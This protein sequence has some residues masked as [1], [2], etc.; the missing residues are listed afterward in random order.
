LLVGAGLFGKSLRNLERVDPGYRADELIVG[1]M[2]VAGVG[3]SRGETDALFRRVADR[4]GALPGVTAV[5]IAWS[6]PT[7]AGLRWPSFSVP[8]VDPAAVERQSQLLG[9]NAA[10]EDFLATTGIPLQA[11]RWFTAADDSSAPPVVVINEHMAHVYFPGGDAVGH[12]VQLPRFL[13]NRVLPGGCS[14]IVGVVGNTRA[15]V[16]GPPQLQ[17]YA[18]LSQRPDGDARF[19]L[20]RS[21]RNSGALVASVRRALQES[22]P[23]VP[24]ADVRIASTLIDPQVRPWRLGALVFATLSAA[25]LVLVMGG[26]YGAV[27]YAA[28]RRRHEFGIR[29][30]LGASTRDLLSLVLGEWL[31]VV[32]VGGFVG[33][34]LALAFARALRSLL[35]GVTASDS[36]ILV[37]AVLT[38]FVVTIAATLPAALRST[39]VDPR[40][41]LDTQ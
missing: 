12:C 33:L 30:A 6:P 8:G 19:L 7:S 23:D 15:D 9:I 24:F 27:S 34:A 28:A 29:L 41:S 3:Y 37:G 17:L 35:V 32:V 11:G 5:A 40:L 31:R 22:S 39:R 21:A 25:A 13:A 10:T 38:V 26:L 20:V 36:A 14:E 18:P 4:V 1:T 16:Q 2:N